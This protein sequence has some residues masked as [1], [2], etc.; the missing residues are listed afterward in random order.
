MKKNLVIISAIAAMMMASC[1]GQKPAKPVFN[2]QIDSVSYS[3]AMARTNGFVNYLVN[4]MEVDTTYMDEF[5][6]GFMKG[7]SMDSNDPAK[8]A[9]NAGVEIGSSEIGS[10]L[11]QIGISLFGEDSDQKFN[12][13]NYIS[14][15]IDGATGNYSIMSMDQANNMTDSLVQLIYAKVNEEKYKEN[16][17]TGEAFL[18]E[19]A[20]EAGVIALESGVL[21]EVISEGLGDIPSPESTVKVKYTGTLID[22]TEFDSSNDEGIEFP[23]LGVIKGWQEVLQIMPAGSHWKVYIPS[24]LAYGD[25][26]QGTIKPYSVLVFD[27]ELLKIVE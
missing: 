3:Y 7:A 1:G 6:K 14:G 18:A 25:Q 10:V 13:D 8:K 2:N 12:K 4:Q 27:M 19:K 17:E 5:V 22:G 15:F 24:E 11:N 26:D 23:V 9:Y 20:K 16:K 21:Y